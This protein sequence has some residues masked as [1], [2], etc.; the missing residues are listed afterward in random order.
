MRLAREITAVEENTRLVS[1]AV[2]P[3]FNA[4]MVKRDPVEPEPVGTIIA[5]A[6]RV[7]GYDQDCDGSLMARLEHIDFEGKASGW[8]PTHLGIYPSDAVVLSDPG[9]LSRLA[10]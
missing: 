4:K 8:E 3:S 5:F 9:E 6:F 7:V 1:L 2:G 10:Q